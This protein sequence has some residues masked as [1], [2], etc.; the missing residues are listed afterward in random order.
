M[1]NQNESGSEKII[2]REIV[3]ILESILVEQTNILT[4]ETNEIRKFVDHIHTPHRINY[5]MKLQE[6]GKLVQTTV[7][8]HI[9][10]G[11]KLL[12]ADVQE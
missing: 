8:I 11:C 1:E 10:E 7:M 6:P 4:G 5:A 12:Y 2:S 3:P 9:C